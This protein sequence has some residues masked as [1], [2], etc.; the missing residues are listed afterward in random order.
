V[1]SYNTAPFN[2][3]TTSSGDNDA[4]LGLWS[5]CE[6]PVAHF[7]FAPSRATPGNPEPL[8]HPYQGVA[9]FVSGTLNGVIHL[10]HSGVDRAQ[11]WVERLS[12]S[13]VLTP[14]KPTSYSSD[15]SG[16]SNGYGT[17]APGGWTRQLPI[18]GVRNEGAMAMGSAMQ[19]LALLFQPNVGGPLHLSLGAYS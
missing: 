4:T 1:V 8:A 17:L 9:P 19:Q 7:G 3:V 15:S 10:A 5:P 14:A 12:L 13:G 16:V 2:V 11:V 18:L 6:F